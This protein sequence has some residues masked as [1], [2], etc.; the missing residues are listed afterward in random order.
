MN[1]EITSRVPIYFPWK[2][3]F[4]FPPILVPSHTSFPGLYPG[5]LTCL[6]VPPL[7][8]ALHAPLGSYSSLW[9]VVQPSVD[10]FHTNSHPPTQQIVGPFSRTNFLK[11]KKIQEKA[12]VN[13]CH[14]ICPVKIEGIKE[15][16]KGKKSR[17]CIKSKR[18]TRARSVNSDTCKAGRGE[19]LIKVPGKEKFK[20]HSGSLGIC[21]CGI[22][23]QK[24]NRS[25]IIAGDTPPLSRM[26]LPR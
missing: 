10:I 3:A 26:L 19:R 4:S 11:K 7:G 9:R 24:G 21:L 15:R 5:H 6:P 22:K 14:S 16:K 17:G 2:F 13:I 25:D 18:G 20:S 23:K 1:F 8:A 12:T